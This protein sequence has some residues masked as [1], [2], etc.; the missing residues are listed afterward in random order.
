MG[1][2]SDGDAAAGFIRERNPGVRVPPIPDRITVWGLN[3][4]VERA[5]GG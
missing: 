5:R 3:R 4:A 2:G 1:D